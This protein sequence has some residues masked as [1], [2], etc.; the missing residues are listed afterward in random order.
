MLSRRPHGE[1]SSTNDHCQ[2]KPHQSAASHHHFLPI[3]I[4]VVVCGRSLI[5]LKKSFTDTKVPAP[6]PVKI[7][8]HVSYESR[9]HF[10]QESACFLPGGNS[11]GLPQ[12]TTEDGIRLD[13][14]DVSCQSINVD[15]IWHRRNE[16]DVHTSQVS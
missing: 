11:Y 5:T 13:I 16:G 1:N 4:L 3:L 9:Q 10:N 8:F 6:Q 15:L 7:F 2:D 14:G 12:P